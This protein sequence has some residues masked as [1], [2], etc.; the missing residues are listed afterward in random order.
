MH[1]RITT[2][3]ARGA[4][5]PPA[6]EEVEWLRAM[7]DVL[8]RSVTAVRQYS[9]T[10]DT[11][12]GDTMFDARRACQKREYHYYAPYVPASRPALRQENQKHCVRRLQTTS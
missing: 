2:Q 9:L 12:T 1:L 7:R 3:F 10:G 8:P 5:A 4:R 11:P 6:L